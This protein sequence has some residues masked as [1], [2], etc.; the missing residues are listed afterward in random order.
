M[1]N[2]TETPWYKLVHYGLEFFG[3]YYSTYHAIVMSTDDPLKMNR[4]K[5]IFPQIVQLPPGGIWALPKGVWGGKDYGVQILPEVGDLIFLEFSHGDLEYPLW[6]HGSYAQGELP[7]EFDGP[8]I[9]GLKTP[10]GSLV[11]IDDSDENGYILVKNKTSNEYI[12]ISDNM[13]ELESNQIKI[14]KQA[15]ERAILGETLHKLLKEL[16]TEL[17][18][19]STK[20]SSHSHPSHST[21]PTQAAGFLTSKGKLESI[22]SKLD[23]ILSNKVKSE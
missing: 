5:V 14:G 13:L 15:K 2:R 21:P 22:K 17:S 23:T 6:S 10:K 18:T 4:I 12:K 19:L 3:R 16:T 20:I 1:S 8:N 7:S 11:I 9:Y